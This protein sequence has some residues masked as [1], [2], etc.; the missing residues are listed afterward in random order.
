MYNTLFWYYQM[1]IFI[2]TYLLNIINE[3]CQ[4]NKFKIYMRIKY[5]KIYDA[6]HNDIYNNYNFQ[7]RRQSG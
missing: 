4:V 2:I 1:N 7:T 3:Y 5:H 6:K